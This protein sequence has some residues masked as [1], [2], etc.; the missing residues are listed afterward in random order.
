MK[1]PDITLIYNR[2]VNQKTKELLELHSCKNFKFMSRLTDGEY[3]EC[4]LNLH[5]KYLVL[6]FS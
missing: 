3:L 2:E 1:L 5:C 6:L 4:I